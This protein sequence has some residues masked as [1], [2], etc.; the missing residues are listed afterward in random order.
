[1][2]L[3]LAV[4]QQH[5]ALETHSIA[6]DHIRANGH[7]RSNTAVLANLGG[8]VDHHVSSK[9]IRLGLS[10]ELRVALRERR[11]VQTG[12][13]EEVLG[14]TNVHPEPFQIK[15]V[16]FPGLADG[17]E[18]LLLDRGRPQVNPLKNTRVQKVDP[19]VDSVPNKLD[20]LL[21]E[22]IDTRRMGRLV[23]NDTKLG[24]L[25]HLGHHNSTF[26]AMGLVEVRE[27][28]EG[29]VANDIGVEDKEWRIIL[30]QDLLSQLQRPRSAQGFGF[31]GEFN[32]DVVLFLV[33]NSRIIVSTGRISKD[34]N[35]PS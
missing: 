14:L 5:A 24:G 8:R 4:L 15:G 9:D 34:R 28:L 7:I 3:D 10:Q 23:N 20:G 22:T 1:M 26:I 18:G 25:V 30:A 21:D 6:H 2:V 29:V 32:F 12:A 13:T 35:T 31:D 33:L 27:F 11:Q 16:Q 17:G 19:G